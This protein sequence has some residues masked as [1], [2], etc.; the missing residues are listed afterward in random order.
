MKKNNVLILIYIRRKNWLETIQPGRTY[1]QNGTWEDR[2]DQPRNKYL[3][4][5]MMIKK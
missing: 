1:I 2:M 4:I 3:F 5:I